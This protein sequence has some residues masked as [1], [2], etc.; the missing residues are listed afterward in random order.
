[1][2][3]GEPRAR[4]AASSRE[5]PLLPLADHRLEVHLSTDL[6]LPDQFSIPPYPRAPLQPFTMRS[7]LALALALLP[8]S[9][10]LHFYL[11][12]SEAKWFVVMHVSL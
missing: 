2:A 10:A 8:L 9:N 4:A 7:W 5:L 3:S 12:S 6:H 11:D 1:M